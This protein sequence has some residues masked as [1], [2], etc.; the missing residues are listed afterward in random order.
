MSANSKRSTKNRVAKE[1]SAQRKN[2]FKGPKATTPKHNKKNAWHQRDTK[3]IV[4]AGTDGEVV[5][6]AVGPV[7]AKS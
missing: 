7:K 3:R 4:K 2:G 1:W 5:A 6:F